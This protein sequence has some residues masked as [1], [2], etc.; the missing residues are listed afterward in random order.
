MRKPLV[1]LPALVFAGAAAAQGTERPIEYRSAF[2]LFHEHQR[3]YAEIAEI[4]QRPLGTIK[5]WVHRA[6]QDLIAYLRARE[7]LQETCCEL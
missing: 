5:T 2:V 3:S 7:V 4:L 6:R 1:F